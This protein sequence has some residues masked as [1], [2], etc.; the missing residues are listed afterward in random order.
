MSVFKSSSYVG[1][2]LFMEHK[3]KFIYKEEIVKFYDSNLEKPFTE[4]DFT[5]LGNTVD[6]SP[7]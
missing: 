4:H 5:K 6:I 1:H 7:F 2:P 3:V